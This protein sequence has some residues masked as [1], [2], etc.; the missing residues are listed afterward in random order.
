MFIYV[1]TVWNEPY[2]IIHILTVAGIIS[3]TS[4]QELMQFDGVVLAKL[5]TLY[6]KEEPE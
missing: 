1:N 5:E 3:E 2:S 4:V 6:D